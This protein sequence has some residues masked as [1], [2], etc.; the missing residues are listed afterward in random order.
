MEFIAGENREQI[1]MLPNCL[2]D[3]VGEEN[4]VRVIDAFVESLDME[5]LGFEK[6]V[7]NDTGRPMY[8]PKDLLKL[9][10]YGY[11]NRIRSSPQPGKGN[12]S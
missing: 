3:Y 12:T 8:N 11:M 1:T 7:P 2:D 6:S 10:I 9:Y 4:T 5:G